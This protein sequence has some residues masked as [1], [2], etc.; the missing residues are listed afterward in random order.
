MV[1]V[2]RC[3]ALAP[4][5]SRRESPVVNRRD[6]Y[7]GAGTSFINTRLSSST[8]GLFLCV[9]KQG[10]AYITTL[11]P[12]IALSISSTLHLASDEKDGE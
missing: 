8:Y 7:H 5:H 1:F 10:S 2:S 9:L 3:K 6:S 11:N 12:R 4:P